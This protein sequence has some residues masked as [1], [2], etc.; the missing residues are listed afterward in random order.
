[1][2]WFVAH[3][4]AASPDNLTLIDDEG[5][6]HSLKATLLRKTQCLD[7]AAAAR[8]TFQL[9]RIINQF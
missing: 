5:S 8:S 3:V 6:S 9:D 7:K 4:A 1:M 2:V